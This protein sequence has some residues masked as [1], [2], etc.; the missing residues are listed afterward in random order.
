MNL[1]SIKTLLRS[2]ERSLRG[3]HKASRP[4]FKYDSVPERGLTSEQNPSAI[5]SLTRSADPGHVRSDESTCLRALQITHNGNCVT[6]SDRPLSRNER[7]RRKKIQILETEDLRD[8]RDHTHCANIPATPRSNVAPPPGSAP[9]RLSTWCFPFSDPRLLLS[10]RPAAGFVVALISVIVRSDSSLPL[11][12]SFSDPS[13]FILPSSHS[14]A[15]VRRAALSKAPPSHPPSRV[16]DRAA[17][18]PRP[19]HRSIT[20]S[21]S[22]APFL[23]CYSPA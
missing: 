15:P 14:P 4:P 11:S 10:R 6:S 7:Q 20:P 3:S 9:N 1:S 18:S 12:L 2:H 5:L 21:V 23:T 19:R 22:A 8:L 17:R 16:C 13:L